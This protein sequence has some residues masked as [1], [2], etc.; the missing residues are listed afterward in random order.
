MAVH[1]SGLLDVANLVLGASGWHMIL[2]NHPSNFDQETPLAEIL[3]YE[4]IQVADGYEPYPFTYTLDSATYDATDNRVEAP[5]FNATFVGAAAGSVYSHTHIAMIRGRGGD[6]NKEITSI[7]TGTDVFTC[8]G[9]GL[10]DGD[11]VFVTS[12][13]TLPAGLDIELYYANALSTNTFELYTD[14]G[15]TT[16]VNVTSAGSG[17]L[18][19]RYANG[20]LH[21]SALVSGTINP[22]QSKVFQVNNLFPPS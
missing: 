1:S 17:T 9:H 5:S 11:L 18:Y 16:K 2:L 6:A 4:C 21:Q 14:A 10:T 7:D 19:L 20:A 12:T 22:G 15:L 8:T 3:Q 13:G